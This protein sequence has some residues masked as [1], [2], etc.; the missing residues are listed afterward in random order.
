[1]TRFWI[2]LDQGVR[3]VI[4]CL[5]RMHGGEIFVPK[6]PSMR[7]VDMARTVAP[8]CEVEYVGIRPGEKLHEALV[9]D[10][11]SRHTVETTDMFIIQPNH[12]WWRTEN[13][14]DAKPVP[15]GFRYT[16]DTNARWLTGPD[17]EELIAP[18]D[19]ILKPAINQVPA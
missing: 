9:S 11:E 15:E 19:A 3:F 7:L 12:P 6:I 17:L 1:M 10:D 5:E 18:S 14:V 2:T 8:E 4:Q 13:W 16:S